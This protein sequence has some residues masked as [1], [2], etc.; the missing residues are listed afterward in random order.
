MSFESKAGAI[1]GTIVS[2]I[3][4]SIFVGL[5]ICFLK[6]GWI[7]ESHETAFEYLVL[8]LLFENQAK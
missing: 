6:D 4:A 2:L 3:K 5:F 1:L 7:F 8:F